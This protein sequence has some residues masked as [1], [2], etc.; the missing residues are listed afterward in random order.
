MPVVRVAGQSEG[1]AVLVLN[2]ANLTVCAGNLAAFLWVA[3]LQR[4]VNPAD[5]PSSVDQCVPTDRLGP[6]AVNRHNSFLVR[7]V[8]VGSFRRRLRFTIAGVTALPFYH[9]QQATLWWF[10]AVLRECRLNVIVGNYLTIVDLPHAPNEPRIE[11]CPWPFGHFAA[12]IRILGND[13]VFKTFD[14]EV[15]R[16]TRG[17]P[18]F[19]RHGIERCGWW[20]GRS[21]T[22]ATV[23]RAMVARIV[24]RCRLGGRSNG[25]LNVDIRF[26]RCADGESGRAASTA[27]LLLKVASW[28]LLSGGRAWADAAEH[29]AASVR[30]FRHSQRAVVRVSHLIWRSHLPLEV[31]GDPVVP[32]VVLG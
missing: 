18:K 6:A 5:I 19:D 4:R 25:R 21:S 13:G 11:V 7:T 16:P 29:L 31:L 24:R 14:L 30:V 1:A 22:A 32:L 20:C 9:G 2:I 10:G 23:Y 12:G 3:A 8:R 27:G 17:R 26:G 28:N 15:G